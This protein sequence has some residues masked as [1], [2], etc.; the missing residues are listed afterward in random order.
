MMQ[1][2]EPLMK[3]IP[4][5]RALCEP[6]Y[7]PKLTSV[8]SIMH[9]LDPHGKITLMMMPIFLN[10]ISWKN[11]GSLRRIWT[12]TLRNDSLLWCFKDENSAPVVCGWL[13]RLSRLRSYANFAVAKKKDGWTNLFLSATSHFICCTL[14]PG[15][16]CHCSGS[17]IVISSLPPWE[18][19]PFPLVCQCP[20]LSSLCGFASFS[21]GSLLATA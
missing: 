6:T 11:C 12:T 19:C 17:L 3:N 16:I 18:I 7:C 1:I 21:S 15:Y 2:S 14:W 9:A 5:Q 10:R 8:T 13:Y 4:S 20:L